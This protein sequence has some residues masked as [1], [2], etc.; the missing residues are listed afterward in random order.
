MAVLQTTTPQT[1]EH[2]A[3][4]LCRIFDAETAVLVIIE[5]LQHE[6]EAAVYNKRWIDF[7]NAQQRLTRESGRLEMLEAERCAIFDDAESGR[8][9]DFYLWASAYPSEEREHLLKSYRA[10]KRQT[11]KIKTANEA[12]SAYLEEMQRVVALFLDAAFPERRGG[13]YGRYGKTR[14]ADMRRVVLDKQF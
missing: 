6:I 3:E 2:G 12:F 10:L 9:V 4:K 11:A 8:E 7:D 14:G 13:L 1:A 5:A